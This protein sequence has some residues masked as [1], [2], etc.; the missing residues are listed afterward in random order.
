MDLCGRFQVDGQKTLYVTGVEQSCTDDGISDVFVT[1]GKISKIIRV[2]DEPYQPRGRTL[3]IYES[4]QAIL[5]IDPVTLGELQSPVDPS[6]IW[7]SKTVRDITQGEMGKEVARRY[8]RELEV[9]GDSGKAGFL[10]FLQSELQAG[11]TPQTET[12]LTNDQDI[13]ATTDYTE[14]S[15]PVEPTSAFSP[16]AEPSTGPVH[17]DESIYNPSHVQKV[18]VEHII[19]NE[20]THTPLAHAKI[21][22]FSGRLPR[23]NGEVDYETWRTQV[24]LLLGDSSLTDAH[25]VRKILESLLSPA[26][27]VVKPLGVTAL[28]G[29]YVTQLES[30]FGVVE[31]GEELFTAFLGSNQNSG[32]KPSAFLSR[33]HSLLTRV[34]SRGELCFKCKGTAP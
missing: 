27:E 32:E 9:L 34:I 19:R 18:V 20:P 15:E 33:L 29:A 14:P 6:V 24:D 1:N 28:P 30:A 12:Q 4:E 31:D 10:S 26:S 16:R 3:V 25:K 7:F 17:I 13:N 11:P 23:P 8:L 22:T 5:K 21:R 2:P